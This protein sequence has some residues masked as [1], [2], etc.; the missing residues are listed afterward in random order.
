MSPDTTRS[1][2][3]TTTTTTAPVERSLG[4]SEGSRVRIANT[5][6][7]AGLKGRVDRLS[8]GPT[9]YAIVRLDGS[10]QPGIFDLDE[11]E[12]IP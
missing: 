2:I 11:L 9:T 5:H 8:I 3:S 7:D 4:L 6:L 12:V 10:D 1:P